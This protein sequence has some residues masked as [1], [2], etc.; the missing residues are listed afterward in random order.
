[1]SHK[2]GKTCGIYES[3]KEKDGQEEGSPVFRDLQKI[4]KL[5]KK[6][7]TS[8]SLTEKYQVDLLLS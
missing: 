6:S 7:V 8:S 3:F 5:K 1:M 2:I 4:F